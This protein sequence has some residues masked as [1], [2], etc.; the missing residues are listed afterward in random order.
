MY[1]TSIWL[2]LIQCDTTINEAC[3]MLGASELIEELINSLFGTLL[4]F[5]DPQV[6]IE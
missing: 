1:N 2:H 5:P 4:Y 6:S 3:E